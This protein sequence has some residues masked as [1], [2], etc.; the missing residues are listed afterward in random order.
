MSFGKEF[1]LQIILGGVIAGAL[2][3]AWIS[4][5]FKPLAEARH[6]LQSVQY[7][8]DK[9]QLEIQTL[10]FEK[11][12]LVRERRIAELEEEIEQKEME[13]TKLTQ[14]LDRLEKE[15]RRQQRGGIAGVPQP[16][17]KREEGQ[18]DKE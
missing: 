13:K 2:I 15:V 9:A 8:R 18:S 1:W 12:Q 10:Q 6:Q 16:I 14:E 5:Y 7:E 11:E 17:E 3:I 4:V